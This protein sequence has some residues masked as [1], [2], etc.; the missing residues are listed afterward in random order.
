MKISLIVDW[1]MVFRTAATWKAAK[2][3]QTQSSIS[4]AV[5]CSPPSSTKMTSKEVF[6]LS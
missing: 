3:L 4:I 6:P 1:K 5:S 2:K